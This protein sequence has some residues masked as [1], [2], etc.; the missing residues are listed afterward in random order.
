M[1]LQDF[2]LFSNHYVII[3]ALQKFDLQARNKR[4]RQLDGF[5][6]KTE[7][8]KSY[9]E[10]RFERLPAFSTHTQKELPKYN[11]NQLVKTLLEHSNKILNLHVDSDFKIRKAKPKI[12]DYKNMSLNHH[13]L[14]IVE[15]DI[16]KTVEANVAEIKAA[17]VNKMSQSVNFPTLT[18]RQLPV[19][20]SMQ[21]Q[22]SQGSVDKTSLH[23]HTSESRMCS[24]TE[25]TNY[26]KQMC[27]KIQGNSHNP[28]WRQPDFGPHVINSK[29]MPTPRI[30]INHKK[31][32]IYCQI[33]KVAC[34]TWTGLIAAANLNY[35]MPK[36]PMAAHSPSRLRKAGITFT[37]SAS[38]FK[39]YTKFLIVRNPLDRILSAYYNIVNK[40]PGGLGPQD[41]VITA[42]TKRFNTNNKN[43]TFAQ[44]V[45]F[46][47]DKT[48]QIS[49]SILYDRHFDTYAHACKLCDI[50][51]DYVIRYET[52]A[53]DSKPILKALGFPEDYF[54]K[55]DTVHKGSR[56][57]RQFGSGVSYLK[58]YLDLNQSQLDKLLQRYQIDMRLFGYKFNEKFGIA[59]CKME[60]MLNGTCC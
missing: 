44:F 55:A 32:L 38:I 49:A 5:V 33:S 12:A 1:F 4:A 2:Q 23:L 11:N 26:I 8:K 46:L 35:S 56:A 37:S 43:L 29:I 36:V 17:A 22:S 3:S 18:T 31:K 50:D 53:T 7:V 59:S 47:T 16:E 58:E 6:L 57:H 10:R 27:S 15:S 24:H 54:L 19:S 52:M 25:R 34:T 21:L 51:Y 45:D 28:H 13:N 41:F 20:N 14:P 30:Y 39:H 60:D 40:E 9:G 42:I 48:H